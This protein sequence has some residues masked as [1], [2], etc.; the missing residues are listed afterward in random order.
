M[1]AKN[2]Q[3]KQPGR[4]NYPG[5][6]A[7]SFN[8]RPYLLTSFPAFYPAHLLAYLVAFGIPS[9][10]LYGVQVR[11]CPVWLGLLVGLQ[12]HAFS[13]YELTLAVT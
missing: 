1:T 3:N 7:P 6:G 4:S 5:F 2:E 11:A 13:D 12:V 8:P 9:G 10:I